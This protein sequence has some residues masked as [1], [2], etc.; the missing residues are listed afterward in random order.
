MK[1]IDDII[2]HY[3]AGFD[4]EEPPEGHFDRF[5]QRLDTGNGS[6]RL[7]TLPLVFKIAAVVLFGLFFSALLYKGIAFYTAASLEDNCVNKELCEAENYYSKQVE[8]YYNRIEKLPFS[9]DPQSRVEIMKE[10]RDMDV[11]IEGMKEDLKQN[12]ND[13][14][15]IHSIINFY[16]EKIDLMDMIISRTSVSTNAIL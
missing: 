6:G 2:R 14:R 15:V 16:Q 5:K 13:E 9:N 1:P 8:K 12:P 10:L 3:K 7:R 4:T 11:Q